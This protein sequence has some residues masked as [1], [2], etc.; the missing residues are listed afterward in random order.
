MKGI[1]NLKI[2]TESNEGYIDYIWDLSNDKFEDDSEWWEGQVSFTANLIAF[3][4]FHANNNNERGY[5][6]LDAITFNYDTTEK[7]TL[8]PPNAAIT[9]T[10]SPNTTPNPGKDKFPN[11]KFE[12]NTC[13]WVTDEYSNM[14]WMRTR[15][16]DL[17]DEGIYD[18]PKNNYDGYF[19]YVSARDGH[20]MDSTT[21]STGDLLNETVSGCLAFYYSIY[22]GLTVLDI[23]H[24]ITCSA[25][26]R[27]KV[28]EGVHG[29]AGRLH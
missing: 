22:V 5:A 8:E 14:K 29:G 15:V 23:I 17:Q 4:V 12:S 20:D 11:C 7:C 27:D 16:E 28:A 9:T 26:G 18:P 2:Y 1:S 19:M 3:Q 24:L 21:L 25:P 10:P 13:G 6:A